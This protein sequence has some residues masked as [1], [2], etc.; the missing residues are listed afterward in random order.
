VSLVGP[1]AWKIIDPTDQAEQVG[2]FASVE[3]QDRRLSPLKRQ[4]TKIILSYRTK[5]LARLTGDR[6][7]G[8]AV[9]GTTRESCYFRNGP[10]RQADGFWQRPIKKRQFANMLLDM[11]LHGGAC[12]KK[13]YIAGAKPFGGSDPVV[14]HK[15]PVENANRL[16]L[17]VVPNEFA[18]ATVPYQRSRL[19]IVAFG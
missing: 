10:H 4:V 13:H 19:A 3:S 7:G 14:E 9:S 12:R 15:P 16:I 11:P 18:G 6:A 1:H 2:F 17:L 8:K 5:Q